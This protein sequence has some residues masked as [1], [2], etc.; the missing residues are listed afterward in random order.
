MDALR[1]LDREANGSKFRS[2]FGR[3][4]KKRFSRDDSIDQA[5]RSRRSVMSIASRYSSRVRATSLRVDFRH[6]P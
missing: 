2:P 5:G 6:E 3:R 1:A 4:F